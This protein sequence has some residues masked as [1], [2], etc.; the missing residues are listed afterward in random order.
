MHRLP[1]GGDVD[2]LGWSR[3]A[4]VGTS[5]SNSTAHLPS[6]IVGRM[7][8][9]MMIDSDGCNALLVQRTDDSTGNFA[10]VRR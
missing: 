1:Y 9:L 6:K 7:T 10:A 3:Y 8:V 5:A 2:D 4:A